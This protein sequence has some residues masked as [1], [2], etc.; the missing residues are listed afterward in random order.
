ML[1]TKAAREIDSYV[2]AGGRVLAEART[3]WNNE[4][5]WATPVIPGGGL[6]RVF[7]CREVEVRPRKKTSVRLKWPGVP[8]QP[9][10]AGTEFGGAIYEETLRVTTPGAQVVGSFQDGAPQ[11][12]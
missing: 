9:G 3:A 6:D 10:G 2:S 12:C 8:A 4:R 7:G 1:S 11:W 5:G